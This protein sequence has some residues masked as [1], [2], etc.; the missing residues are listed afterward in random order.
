MATVTVESS[1][2]GEFR[3]RVRGGSNETTHSVTV[4]DADYVRLTSRRIPADELV[5]RSFEFLLER[6]P[7]E[8]ILPRFDLRVIA[9]YFPEYDDEIR[10]RLADER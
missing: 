2:P 5:R 7:K 8:S 9:R 1:G 6:E 4:A 3:V 10:R